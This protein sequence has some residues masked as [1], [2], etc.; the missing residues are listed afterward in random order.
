MKLASKLIFSVVTAIVLILAIDGFISFKHQRDLF[1]ADMHHDI[2]VLG[3][4]I[5]PLVIETWNSDGRERAWKIIED[6]N[7]AEPSIDVRWVWLNAP[8]GQPH[9]PHVSTERL[10]PVHQDQLLSLTIQEKGKPGQFY[11]Y[12]PITINGEQPG[13][14]E[15]HES[16]A[17]LDNMD[18]HAMIKII[19]LTAALVFFSAI[20]ALL[21]GIHMIGRPLEQMV[22]KMRR[23]GT[24]DFSG[25]V[26]ISGHDELDELAMGMNGMCADLT[27]A[28]D[29]VQQETEAR[30][31]AMEQ[32]RHED[33]LK[34]VDDSP[35]ALP[36]KWAPPSTSFRVM[37]A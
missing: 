31:A 7:Q 4:A 11:A 32:L 22:D 18:H 15:F 14:L 19:S 17:E 13:A 8:L 9:A 24:G 3:L 37:P 23:I 26:E 6:A 36:T 34:T 16:L 12:F 1:E 25:N 29:K 33:R 21:L 28:W 27:E 30:I 2:R 35:R 20:A 10:K 5:R